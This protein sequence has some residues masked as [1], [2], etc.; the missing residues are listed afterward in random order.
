MF[1]FIY[2]SHN[3]IILS[4]C[5]IILEIV[6]LS[7]LSLCSRWK[8]S[9]TLGCWWISF[10]TQI[11]LQNVSILYFLFAFAFF[12]SSRSSL[13]RQFPT[14]INFYSNKNMNKL[15]LHIRRILYVTIKW[16]CKTGEWSFRNGRLSFDNL[17]TPKI[18]D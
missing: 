10:D 12:Y 9:Q 14:T 18:Y 6:I 8:L 13:Y 7:L 16:K 4:W 1:R 17:L 5:H 2:E 11:L 15:D 3:V